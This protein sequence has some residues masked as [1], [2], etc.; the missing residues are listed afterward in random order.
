MLVGVLGVCQYFLDESGVSR[1][2]DRLELSCHSTN[3]SELGSLFPWGENFATD[4]AWCRDVARILD[5]FPRSDDEIA[6]MVDLDGR[7]AG[8][9][10]REM[11]PISVDSR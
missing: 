8:V 5:C 2:G 9:R 6:E 4:L 11:L 10:I 1:L 3:F 7:I